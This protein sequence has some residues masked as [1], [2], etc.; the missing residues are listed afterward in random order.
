MPLNCFSASR[1]L[2][3]YP[4]LPP[5]LLYRSFF[6][7][8]PL[9]PP[10]HPELHPRPPCLP[11]LLHISL[12]TLPRFCPSFLLSF[13]PSFPG[14]WQAHKCSNDSGGGVS[15]TA[16]AAVTGARLSLGA[17]TASASLASPAITRDGEG[18]RKREKWLKSPFHP[19]KFIYQVFL[20]FQTITITMAQ[21]LF[22]S[23]HHL[24]VD[25][26]L[27]QMNR[28]KQGCQTQTHLEPKCKTFGQSLG[29]A[30]ILIEKSKHNTR[31]RWNNS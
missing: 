17:N 4:S 23:Q 24:A 20:A 18:G 25:K 19:N 11:S 28:L 8:F 29:P 12:S 26:D 2:H 21:S 7:L 14:E 1:F 27:E 15:V 9:L 16:I 30:L 22:A 31:V 3:S 5:L 10:P 13:A 6:S